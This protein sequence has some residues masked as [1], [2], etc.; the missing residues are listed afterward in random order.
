MLPFLDASPKKDQEY[1]SDGLA[2]EILDLLTKV[3]DLQVI[4]RTSSFSFKGKSDDVPTIAKILNVANI[5]QGSVRKSGDRLRVSTELVRADTG[6]QIWS[7]TYDRDLKD[8]F[9]IQDEIADAVVAALKLKLAPGQQ[10]LSS[11]RTANIEAYNEYLLGRQFYDRHDLD[12]I[13][14]A[15]AAYRKA[16]ELDPGYAAAY[17][18]LANSEYFAADTVGDAAGARRALE[19]ADKAV[20]LAPDQADGYAARGQIRVQF[21]WNWLG[22]QQDFQKAL[23]I[24]PGNSMALRR[25]GFLLGALGRLPEAIAMTRKAIE[26]DPL[27]SVTWS[28]LGMLLT[29]ARQ[30]TAADDGDSQSVGDSAGVA[31]RSVPP[32]HLTVAR[33]QGHAGARYSAPGSLGGRSS[34]GHGE[35][36]V[37]PGPCQGI[38]AGP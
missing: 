4:A 29:G 5:V 7:E 33:R 19:A 18:E 35:G 38:S 32:R 30:F 28:N 10:A 8:V 20:A 23:A 6:V 31:L 26:L 11:H 21:A 17:A 36:R 1:F 37:F 2:E 9:K 3:P 24:D 25:Y 13:Q 15:V 16:V 14:H 12:G 34:A 27:S 22:A